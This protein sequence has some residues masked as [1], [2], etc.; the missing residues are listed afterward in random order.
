MVSERLGERSE[1]DAPPLLR[2]PMT[3]CATVTIIGAGITGI[4]A[5]YYFGES[6]IPY[7]VLEARSDIGGIWASQRWH[8]ARCDSDIIKYSYSFMPFLSDR[9]LHERADIQAYLRSVV[10]EFGILKH[11]RFDTTVTRA[12]FDTGEKLWRIETNR[13]TFTS[14]FL[15]NGNGYLSETPYVPEFAGAG[16]FLGEIVHTSHL[17]DTRTFEDKDVVL[18]GSGATAVCCAPPLADVSRSLTLVQR[19]PSYIYEITNRASL[20]VRLSQQLY[21]RGIALPVHMVRYALQLK[22]DLIFV[23]FRRMPWLGRWVFR[24]HWLKDVGQSAVQEHFTPR[25]D[26]WT[27]RIPVAIGLKAKLR[28]GLIRMRSGEIERFTESGLVLTTGEAISCDVCVLATGFTLDF[29]KFE[30]FV[31]ER[32]ISIDRLNFYKGV[33]MGAIPNYFQPVGVWHSAWTQRSESATRFAIEIIR[34]ME[35]NRY[36]MITI[37]RREVPGVP[38]ITPNYITRHPDLPR[39]YGSLELPALDRLVSYWFSPREFQFS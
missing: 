25:Y 22:D 35:T 37:P 32:R 39:V 30:L 31:D 23:A 8:G 28:A 13:G 4:G 14:R 36:E 26:P 10:E 29:L 12:T 5:A 19:S 27:Q 33:M 6:A 38:T 18:V 20:P 3:T 24:R 34:Y 1:R 11:I 2:A 7:V 9:S 21:R 15:V 17:D 16:T